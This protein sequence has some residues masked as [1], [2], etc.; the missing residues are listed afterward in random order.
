MKIYIKSDTEKEDLKISN[1]DKNFILGIFKSYGIPTVVSY[2]HYY[3]KNDAYMC[4]YV[5]INNSNIPSDVITVRNLYKD[6]DAMIPGTGVDYPIDYLVDEDG[7][8]TVFKFY[9]C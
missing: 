7:E 3:R 9:Y 5:E 2:D 6:L 1:H 8:N 4:F